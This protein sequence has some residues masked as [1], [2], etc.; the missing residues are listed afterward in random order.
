MLYY[1]TTSKHYRIFRFCFN[2]R[3]FQKMEENTKQN[4]RP[5][6]LDLLFQRVGTYRE[7][8][9]FQ[10]LLQFVKRFG[11]LAPYNAMLIHIQRPGSAYVATAKDWLQKFGR[12]VR[13]GARP[14]LILKPFRPIQF[15]FEVQDTEG[16]RPFP[17]QLLN[18]FKIPAPEH[19]LACKDALSKLL[20]NL[21][22][23]G[24]SFH[25]ADNGSCRA[26]SIQLAS[27][28]ARKY[29]IYGNNKEV[30]VKYNLIVNRNL[31]VVETFATVLHEL[32][33]LYCGHLGTPDPSRWKSR[34]SHDKNIEEFEAEC[35]SWIVCARMGIDSRSESYLHSYL[36]SN[37]TI[38][39]ISLDSVLKA[40]GMIE[41]R[42]SGRIT[43][44]KTLLKEKA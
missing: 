33:H 2:N 3:R 39:P 25:E 16:D 12:T 5:G 15:V 26:G 36:D 22:A 43:P 21:P 11:N 1:Y 34:N 19:A 32:G 6:E 37:N 35:V 4:D 28:H 9:E 8:N 29:Q 17:E 41:D 13:P 14:L 10:D 18:P 44:C 30:L 42:I 40:A 20:F 27:T 24:I 31:G 38:P 7:S 23:D